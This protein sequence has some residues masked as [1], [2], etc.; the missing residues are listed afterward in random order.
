MML[1]S[2]DGIN[3]GTGHTPLSQD[4]LELYGQDG[5]FSILPRRRDRDKLMIQSMSD[6][7]I[8]HTSPG[9]VIS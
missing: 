5:L 2:L 6:P 7:D 4:D 1:V 3:K 9:Q 8:P